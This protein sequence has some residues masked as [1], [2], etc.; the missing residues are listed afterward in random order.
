MIIYKLFFECISAHDLLRKKQMAVKNDVGNKSEFLKTC[1][2]WFAAYLFFVSG[3]SQAVCNPNMPLT[4][5]DSRYELIEGVNPIGSEVRDRVTGLIWQ[6]CLVGMVWNGA[7][8]T[9]TAS[10]LTWVSALEVARNASASTIAPSFPWRVPNHA[11]LFNLAERSCYKPAINT[12]W[13]PETASEFTLTSSAS[14]RA[15]PSGGSNNLLLS[16]GQFR[17][18]HFNAGGD[19]L[20]YDMSLV[21]ALRLV[22]DEK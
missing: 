4:R 14:P 6:R 22:R 11:E 19:S 15:N 16:V 9:G 2:G 8:C 21:G 7:T 10:K 1:C 17:G 18:I 12:T 13:F 20:G 3:T 5:P